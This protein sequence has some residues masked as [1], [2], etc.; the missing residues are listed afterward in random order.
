MPHFLRIPPKEKKTKRKKKHFWPGFYEWL[1]SV[2]GSDAFSTALSTHN[3]QINARFFHLHICY[4]HCH[5]CCCCALRL[6]GFECCSLFVSF[7]F[8]SIFFFLAFMIIAVI[9]FSAACAIRFHLFAIEI[10]M[11][12]VTFAH[13][14]NAF[15]FY[16]INSLFLLLVD[17]GVVA[18][19]AGC[20]YFQKRER[21]RDSCM[22]WWSNL[23]RFY[24]DISQEIHRFTRAFCTYTFS[25]F[26]LMPRICVGILLTGSW[27]ILFCFFCLL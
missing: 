4:C 3:P 11:R 7:R 27:C 19:A 1:P 25:Q 15:C 10:F 2:A 8:V 9:Q 6:L 16:T 14:V 5:C 21:E 12:C 20:C 24:I 22:F 23:I 18:T 13:C 26:T 17:G